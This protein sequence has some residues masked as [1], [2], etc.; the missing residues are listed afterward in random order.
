MH[1]ASRTLPTLYLEERSRIML[2]LSRQM[3]K[4]TLSLVVLDET[5]SASQ[6]SA[7]CRRLGGVTV[8]ENPS[9][10]FLLQRSAGLQFVF[11]KDACTAT[12]TATHLLT[13]LCRSEK[14]V[15]VYS[16]E[17]TAKRR[18]DLIRH[19]ATDAIHLDDINSLRIAS[20]LLSQFSMPETKQYYGGI[21]S[22][23]A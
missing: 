18:S 16:A 23:C 7:M 3:L 6:I 13:L 4:G 10:S 14:R 8:V 9:H 1:R 20:M 12:G 21:G 11:L 17:M 5:V 19:G 15:I 2:D 22:A